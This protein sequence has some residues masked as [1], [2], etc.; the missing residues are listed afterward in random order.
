VELD[1]NDAAVQADRHT[2][3][4]AQRVA[5]YLRE[6]AEYARDKYPVTCGGQRRQGGVLVGSACPVE[7]PVLVSSWLACDQVM[8]E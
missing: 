8:P 5:R 6:L 2:D 4:L 3:V 1:G 7:E